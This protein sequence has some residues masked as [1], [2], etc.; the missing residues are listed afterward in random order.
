MALVDGGGGSLSYA[1]VEAVSGRL[2]GRLAELGVGPE[3]VVGVLMER[4]A[5]LVLVAAGDRARRAVRTLP[6]NPW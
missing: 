4:S 2:A 6:L 5:D 1:E 3:T